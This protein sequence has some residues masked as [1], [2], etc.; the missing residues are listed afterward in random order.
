MRE[1]FFLVGNFIHSLLMSALDK[2]EQQVQQ[3]VPGAIRKGGAAV[4]AGEKAANDLRS[5]YVGS[6]DYGATPEEL[7]AHFASCGTIDRI[8]ILCDKW[9]GKPK[10]YAYVMFVK[11]NDSNAN[12]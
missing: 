3:A 7:Q 11:V 12:F 1:G 4:A 9:T 2:V 5:V 10:G 6:V 8:T